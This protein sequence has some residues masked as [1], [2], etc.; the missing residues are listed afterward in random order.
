VNATYPFELVGTGVGADCEMVAGTAASQL[1][2]KKMLK[3]QL[4]PGPGIGGEV[5]GP[6]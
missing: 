3:S 6:V 5:F 1:P 2:L 4:E